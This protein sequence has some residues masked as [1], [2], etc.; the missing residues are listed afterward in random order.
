LD[1][2]RGTGNSLVIESESAALTWPNLWRSVYA[3]SLEVLMFRNFAT[4]KVNNKRPSKASAQTAIEK[5][6]TACHGE[7]F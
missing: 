6:P 4:E 5:P 2:C 3:S 7:K 1:E